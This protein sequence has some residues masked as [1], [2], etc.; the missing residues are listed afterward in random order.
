VPPD[1]WYFGANRQKAMPFSVLLEA[2]LQPCGFLAAY[3]GSAL[4]TDEPLSFRNLDGTA[5]AHREIFS[6]AQTLTMR[7]RLTKVA[8]AGGML[9]Q[10]FDFEV[11][12]VRGLVYAG[13][14]GFGFFP[15]AALAQQVGLRGGASWKLGATGGRALSEQA[16]PTRGLTLPAKGYAMIDRVEALSLDG[17]PNGLGFV[18]GTKQVDPSEWF[19]R[20]HFFQD[21]VMPGSLGLEAL[22]QLL[23]IY[24]RERFPELV[25]THRLQSMAIDRPH[26][27][28]YRGQVVPTNALVSVEARVTLVTDEREPLIIADGQLLCDGK[29]IYAM[30][31]F[32]VRLVPEVP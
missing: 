10:E 5:T 25:E 22:Q 1:A 20:A 12:D 11:S 9:L 19:F 23:L 24:A 2:A 28:Q 32:S 29:P 21:P 31:D 13:H 17:G 26:V 18:S 27:W 3:A 15:P 8:R 16:L 7:S 4:T 6:D 14:T 30:K